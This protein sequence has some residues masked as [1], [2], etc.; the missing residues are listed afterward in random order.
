MAPIRWRAHLVRR[1]VDVVAALSLVS[2][3]AWQ[4]ELGLA[5]IVICVPLGQTGV[6]CN[7]DP[8]TATPG[9]LVPPGH[10]AETQAEWDRLDRQQQDLDAKW[11]RLQRERDRQERQRR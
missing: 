1:V 7:E 6:F 2:A 11:E 10:A 4:L 3:L 8:E 5:G 9:F